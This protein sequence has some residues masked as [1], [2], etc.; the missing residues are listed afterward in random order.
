MKPATLS[1]T[2]VRSATGRQLLEILAPRRLRILIIALIILA[3]AGLELVPPL[4]LRRIVDVHLA[5]GV[6]EGLWL[7]ALVCLA[8]MGGVQGLGF[9]TSAR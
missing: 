9:L 8:S 3:G 1:S 4:A 5:P 2:T 6:A 7:L